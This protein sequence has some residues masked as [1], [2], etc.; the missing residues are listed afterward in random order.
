M[1]AL[2][3]TSLKK[4]IPSSIQKPY[5]SMKYLLIITILVAQ[6]PLLT[7]AALAAEKP[8]VGKLYEAKTFGKLN[9]RLMSP[10]D[11]KNNTEKKYP[12]I[13][14]L[15]G[16]GGRGTKNIKNLRRWNGLLAEESLRRKYPCYVLAPQVV[17]GSWR[18]PKAWPNLK[19]K[20]FSPAWDKL[21]ARLIENKLS[22]QGNLDQIFKL[23][24]QMVASGQV[25][26]DRV[27]VLGHSLG[28][29]GSWTSL[30]W[31][32]N[33]FAAA[34]PCAGGLFPPFDAQKFAHVPIWAFHGDRDTTVS[35][36]LTQEAFDK[37]KA[38]NGNMKYTVLKGVKHGADSHAFQYKGDSIKKGFIT[39]YSSD[40][41]DK[42]SAVWEWL[43]A[44]KRAQ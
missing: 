38:V 6:L 30:G 8:D 22:T 35:T 7:N 44:Q 20:D 16:A 28:G 1:K 14:S 13:L 32:P 36:A 18:M 5:Y 10:I 40:K 24:D 33:R 39:H 17:E 25:D 2:P 27:Y 42:T 19:D 34:I 11:L 43:F 15:H 26:A 23:I 29:F 9:Y 3:N 37:V 31:A 21:R 4:Q 41:C 12:L